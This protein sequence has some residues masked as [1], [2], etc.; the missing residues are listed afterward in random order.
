MPWTTLVRLYVCS[1]MINRAYTWETDRDSTSYIHVSR[2]IN[3]M[4]VSFF[5]CLT[6][7]SEKCL[8]NCRR[9]RDRRR[10]RQEQL[11][12]PLDLPRVLYVF[13]SEIRPRPKSKSAFMESR[14]TGMILL[15]DVSPMECDLCLGSRGLD[16]D[17]RISLDEAHLP[18][19]INEFC[20]WSMW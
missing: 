11:L 12:F 6:G 8:P 14:Q 2:Q 4:R 16:G 10:R 20:W 15:T 18:N 19:R 13:Y 9:S 3:N 7:R 17:R 1:P 5:N